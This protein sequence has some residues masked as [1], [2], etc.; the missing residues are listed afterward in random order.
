MVPFGSWIEKEKY[1]LGKTGYEKIV[2]ESLPGEQ[3]FKDLHKQMK[4]GE[5]AG[6]DLAK[7][8]AEE[9][10]KKPGL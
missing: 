9:H 4:Q 3:S 2:A 6:G 10:E 7:K 1:E 5:S 8:M